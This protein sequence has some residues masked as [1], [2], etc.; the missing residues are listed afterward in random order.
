M[1][2]S[3]IIRL[4][5]SRQNLTIELFTTFKTDSRKALY[6]A[7]IFLLLPELALYVRAESSLCF[8]NFSPWLPAGIRHRHSTQ[9]ASRQFFRYHSS[10]NAVQPL[11][12]NSWAQIA[13]PEQL[14]PQVPPAQWQLCPSLLSTPCASILLELIIR[15]NLLSTSKISVAL[16]TNLKNQ[17]NCVK[18]ISSRSPHNSSKT[19]T[20]N[21]PASYQ[22]PRTKIPTFLAF[23]QGSTTLYLIVQSRKSD[24]EGQDQPHV[25]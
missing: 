11:P 18:Q 24:C 7:T 12:P 20:S 10:A 5:L 15:Y 6:S 16:S 2:F 8:E 19:S 25:L 14:P 9:A 17:A 4:S 13:T 22:H 23:L 1:L 3:I 21:I